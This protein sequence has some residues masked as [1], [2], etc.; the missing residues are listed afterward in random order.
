M[1]NIWVEFWPEPTKESGSHAQMSTQKVFIE[2]DP[3]I[4][5]QRFFDSREAAQRFA[6]K[7][8]ETGQ[9]ARIKADG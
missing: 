8:S 6:K 4:I 9:V 3:K 2:P 5:N 7:L 1:S